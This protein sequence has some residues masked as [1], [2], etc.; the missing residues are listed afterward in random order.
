MAGADEQHELVEKRGV[1]QRPA[2]RTGRTERSQYLIPICK[3]I[4]SQIGRVLAHGGH[5]SH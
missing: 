1:Q 5:S 2:E 3:L 4:E